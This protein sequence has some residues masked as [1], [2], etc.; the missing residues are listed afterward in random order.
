MSLALAP[1]ASPSPWKVAYVAR[2]YYPAGDRH[3]SHHQVY[4]SDLHGGHVR[5][6]TSGRLDCFTVRWIDPKTVAWTREDGTLWRLRVDG[7][8]PKLWLRKANLDGYASVGAELREP[9]R[10]VFRLDRP[11]W[12]RNGGFVPFETKPTFWQGAAEGSKIQFRPNPPVSTDE[13]DPPG[14]LYDSRGALKLDFVP[15]APTNLVTVFEGP[16]NEDLWVLYGSTLSS[17]GDY[18]TLARYARFSGRV[19]WHIDD[20]SDL[21]FR[22]DRTLYALTEHRDTS[23]LGRISVWTA[24]IRI[25]DWKTGQQWQISKG[26]VD[27]WSV[28][29]RP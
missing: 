11:Y 29:L 12:Y 15:N 26:T 19:R 20:I 13:Y 2:V 25:G 8:T 4:L 1:V 18:F 24:P 28:S 23:P 3:L 21:D 5:Q 22:P 16:T 6:V 7:G 9:G 10:P 27:N 14:S 17:W